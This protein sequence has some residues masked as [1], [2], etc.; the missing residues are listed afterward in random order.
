MLVFAPVVLLWQSPRPPCARA[1]IIEAILVLSVLVLVGQAICGGFDTDWPKAY[2]V[3]PVLLWA[4]LR[5]GR[6]GTVA[7]LLVLTVIA[8]YGTLRGFEVFAGPT[9]NLSLLHLQIFLCV[10]SMMSLLVAG[11]VSEL[12]LANESLENKIESRTHRLEE[13]MREKDDLMAIAAHDLQAPLAGMR[14]LL[15]L[16]QS[17]P[18]TLSSEASGRVL[19]EMETTTDGMLAL[20]SSLLTAKRAEELGMHLTVAPCDA[21]QLVGG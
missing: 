7:A 3:I 12:R 20:V 4:A 14:N 15:R 11:L 6:R 10:V 18:E 19:H 2:L 16:V 5:L 9:P 8:V 13:M 17:R 1:H 21:V